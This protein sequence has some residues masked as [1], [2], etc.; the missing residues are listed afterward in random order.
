MSVDLK[1][2]AEQTGTV[3]SG[4]ALLAAKVLETPAQPPRRF[5]RMIGWFL[6]GCFAVALLPLA[7]MLWDKIR[8]LSAHEQLLVGTWAVGSVDEIDRNDEELPG[9]PCGVPNY[10]Y[11]F[12]AD[13]TF[14]A[15]K[16]EYF[17]GCG[18]SPGGPMHFNVR[19]R[20]EVQH[21]DVIFHPMKP[22][23]SYSS[24]VQSAAKKLYRG[25]NP[26]PCFEGGYEHEIHVVEWQGDGLL[27]TDNRFR[28]PGVT[29]MTEKMHRS[30]GDLLQL[31]S[32]L[33]HE[34]MP[35][36]LSGE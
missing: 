4:A 19:G 36:L 28:N 24:R 11:R 18:L 35:L 16:M 1:S 14:H 8:P 33:F 12:Y 23:P 2:T 30:N 6:T 20:W 27:F 25:Q 29:S 7:W 5:R 22:L 32:Q 15:R 3:V 21:N 13:R 9:I 31:D 26:L 17:V 10:E 34:T